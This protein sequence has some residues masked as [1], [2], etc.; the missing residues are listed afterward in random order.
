MAAL[1]P[2][3]RVAFSRRAWRLTRRTA[4]DYIPALVFLVLLVLGWEAWVR[5]Y[6]TKPYVLPGPSRIWEAFLETRSTIPGHVRTTVAEAALGLVFSAVV[7]VALA[8]VM[9]LVPF[10]RRV[11]YPLMVVSQTIPMVVLAPLLM[12]W[13][14]FDMTPKVIVVALYG[15]FP[16]VVATVDALTRADPEMVGLVRSMGAG[17]TAVLRHVLIPSALPAFF[18]GLK[19][20]SAYAVLSAVIGEWVGAS[21]GLGVFITRAQTSFRVDRVFVA[22]AVVALVSIAFF[23]LVHLAARLATPWM[24]V[25]DQEEEHS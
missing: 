12:I 20:A 24:Y 9:A 17:R 25:N 2:A 5:F 3:T 18:A 19:I 21:S 13:F 4:W 22:V 11:L 1:A 6:D 15:F 23:A 14:G 8:V 7:G 10:V 16:I